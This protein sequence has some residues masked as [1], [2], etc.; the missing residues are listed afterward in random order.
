MKLVN[1]LYYDIILKSPNAHYN[2][3]GTENPAVKHL[4]NISITHIYLKIFIYLFLE[5]QG[6]KHQSVTALPMPPTGDLAQNPG[7]FPDWESNWWP[8]GLQAGTQ[9]TEQQQPGSITLVYF[10]TVT[11]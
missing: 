2:D 6:G 9:S 11:L 3:T 4:L 1:I 8:F 7:L 10:T 5:G